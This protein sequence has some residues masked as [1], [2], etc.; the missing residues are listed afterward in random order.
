MNFYIKKIQLWFRRDISPKCY[1]FF[2]DKVNVVTGHS[3]TGKSS[4]LRIIDYCLMAPESTIV[5]DVIN[6]NVAWYGLSFHL[7]GNDFIVARRAPQNEIVSFD[8]YWAE[9]SDFPEQPAPLNNLTRGSVI[10]KLNEMFDVPSFNFEISDKKVQLT[11]RHFLL[12]NYLTE[13][14]IAT[15]N[16]YLDTKFF[17]DKEYDLILEDLIKIAIGMDENLEQRLSM[18]HKELDKRIVKESNQ[19]STD[20][21]S[22]K[23]YRENLHNLKQTAIR[24]GLGEDLLFNLEEGDVMQIIQTGIKKYKDFV[25]NS[26]KQQQIKELEREARQL[27]V[28]IS[29]YNIL[30]AEYNKAIVYA[31][32]V[33]DCL[34]PVK[35]LKEHLDEIVLSAETLDLF[36][37]LESAFD[38][39]NSFNIPVKK[40]PTDFENRRKELIYQQESI[41]KKIREMRELGELVYDA[42]WVRRVLMLETEFEKVVRSK[43]KRKFIGDSAL[44]DLK[45]QFAIIDRRLRDI[46]EINGIRADNLNECITTFYNLQ[47]G[48]SDNYTSCTP[49]FDIENSVLKL[50]RDGD[51]K[52][53][54]VKNIGSKSNYM[55]MHLCFFLGLHELLLVNGNNSVPNFLFID[56]P[57]I[58]YYGKNGKEKGN[59]FKGK[60]DTIKLK[61]AFRLINGFMDRNINFNKRAHFQIILI[62]HADPEYWKD[63]NFFETRYQFTED[64]DYGLIPQE[65]YSGL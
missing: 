8:I 23:K 22:Q 50:Y 37:S 36:K 51:K 61:D 43:P 47:H 39:A 62:E 64:K 15:F 7:N 9:G 2:P 59:L 18:Q 45:D 32:S 31:E 55:F 29:S 35:Y 46:K 19:K 5:E 4:I 44:V 28:K 25:E 54:P 38:S 33:K 12:F 41:R 27:K 26:R 58:P 21:E 11:F 48:I 10:A 52:E 30:E 40:L 65:I 3:S 13:D 17:A 16:S 63:F 6:E 56:Q 24:L 34:Q 49:D 1:E 14:I 20:E 60:D 57:S 53:F 42:E